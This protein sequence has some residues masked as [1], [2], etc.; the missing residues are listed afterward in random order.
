MR[1]KF[2]FSS[3]SLSMLSS[4]IY[5]W[6]VDSFKVAVA[7]YIKSMLLKENVLLKAILVIKSC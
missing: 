5:A 2:F 1:R 7:G 4:D 3:R 6:S